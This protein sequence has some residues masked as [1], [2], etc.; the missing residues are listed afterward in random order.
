M[1]DEFEE[2]I[3]FLPNHDYFSVNEKA[4]F[5]IIS[6]SE[7]AAAAKLFMLEK[8]EYKHIETGIYPFVLIDAIL[9]WDEEETLIMELD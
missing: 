9:E 4:F 1:C 5:R 2:E 6:A 7:T 3:I 8:K